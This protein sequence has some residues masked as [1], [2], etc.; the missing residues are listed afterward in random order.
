VTYYN[1]SP[2]GDGVSNHGSE[3]LRRPEPQARSRSSAVTASRTLRK[4]RS[5]MTRRNLLLPQIKGTSDL[6]FASR[7]ATRGAKKMNRNSTVSRLAI[8]F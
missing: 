6:F 5:M 3:Y 7:T 4:A 2:N 8:A 1:A